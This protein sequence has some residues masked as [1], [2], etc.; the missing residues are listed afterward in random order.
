MMTQL[1]G[2]QTIHG[3]IYGSV[4]ELVDARDLKSLV[5]KRTCEFKSRP[6]YHFCKKVGVNMG[7]RPFYVITQM[8]EGD[9]YSADTVYIG[10]NYKAA[11][12]RF[13]FLFESIRDNDYGDIDPDR[14]EA[15][16]PEI[17][18]E[19]PV[20]RCLWA[21]VNDQDCYYTS[22]EL[23]CINTE[24]FRNPG[25]ETAYKTHNPDAKH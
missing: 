21:G 16:F 4:A 5:R 15:T 13:K 23:A 10:T 14:R 3:E 7:K 2:I 6:S 18:N 17:P 25:L 11:I 20:G 12:A 8:N 24:T 19:L 9:G 1:V 22:L